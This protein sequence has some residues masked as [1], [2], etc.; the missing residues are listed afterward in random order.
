MGDKGT[1]Q[2]L[3]DAGHRLLLLK[4]DLSASG[5]VICREAGTGS[6]ASMTQHFPVREELLLAILEKEILSYR[7]YELHVLAD[8]TTE[9][10]LARLKQFISINTSGANEQ[11]LHSGHLL[12]NLAATTGPELKALR[13]R[14]A[15]ALRE[16]ERSIAVTV[17]AAKQ[18]GEFRGT[19][20][21]RAVASLLFAGIQKARLEA[22]LTGSREHFDQFKIDCV[23]LLGQN[24]W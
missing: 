22:R 13:A 18:A 24:A 14:L 9:S 16:V 11:Q 4:G 17:S 23:K 10:P 1:R 15:A 6:P 21:P 7:G 12:S 5:V 20:E 19:I 8:P 2:R 3:I